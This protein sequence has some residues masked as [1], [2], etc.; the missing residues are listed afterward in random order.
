MPTIKF[1]TLGCKVN[2]YETQAIREQFKK[3]GYQEEELFAPADA[4]LINTCTVTNKADS[5]SLYYVRNSL[6]QNPQAKIIVTGC[7]TEHD[8]RKISQIDC[9]IIIIR[10]KDKY[11]I[12]SLLVKGASTKDEGISDF[13]G[14]TRAF[15]KIQDGC[16]NFCSYCK[17]PLVRGS[18]RSKS[19]NRIIQEAQRL[20]RQGFKEIVLT[21]ICLGS[22][23]KDLGKGR[24]RDLVSVI[25]ELEKIEGLLRIRLS[26]IEFKYVSSRLLRK[27]QVSTKLCRH[28]HMPM[29]SGD[30]NI[31]KAMNRK[32]TAEDF[33]VMVNR[34]KKILPGVA[35]T[36]DIL[37]GFP[38]E[39]E[40][41]F[42][43][44][45]ELVKKIKPLK[46]HI[47]P[48]S[49]RPGTKAC[50]LAQKNKPGIVKER[51]LR[52]RQA[53]QACCRD[54]LKDFIGKKKRVLFEAR[55]KE[56]PY[57]W[58]GYTDNYIHVYLKSSDDLSNKFLNVRLLKVHLDS[59]EAVLD[60]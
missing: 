15:L 37:V 2:Q 21:G 18:S 46:V 6:R 42:L 7:L 8:A 4:Y 5:E 30:N 41:N 1:I 23:G 16:D 60:K 29:Q 55:I 43:N 58:Q 33:L 31:L 47:F 45:L 11:R 24:G 40:G 38:L 19:W 36:T 34:I 53:A 54:Y 3:A 26:S 44:T 59:L 52:L 39:E 27:M 9:R 35:I 22:Y 10:N 57:F 17:V 32:Y 20:V 14:H 12:A 56:R 28:L 13:K 48:Y 51:I 49:P 50:K 25:E